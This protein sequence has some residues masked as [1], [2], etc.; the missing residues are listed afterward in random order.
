MI[1]ALIKKAVSA[2]YRDGYSYAKAGVDIVE[3]QDRSHKQ[4]DFFTPGQSQRS[5]ALMVCM[6]GIN[7]KFGRN[8]T[9]VA[10]QGG[11]WSVVHESEN[12]KPCIYHPGGRVS[13][14]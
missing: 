2:L 12:V 14:R 7:T 6:D 1:E 3:L 9:R 8:S 11:L 4:N 5:E 13:P 10:A